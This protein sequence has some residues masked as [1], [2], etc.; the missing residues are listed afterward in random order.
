[1][2]DGIDLACFQTRGS[3]VQKWC[4]FFTKFIGRYQH[5]VEKYSVTCLDN[6]D[7]IGN[8]ILVQS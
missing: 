3:T 4:F 1:M 8:Y 5:L 6:K 2:K 7:N